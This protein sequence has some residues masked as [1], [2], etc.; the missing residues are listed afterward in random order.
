[1][2]HLLYRSIGYLSLNVLLTFLCFIDESTPTI[3]SFLCL[4]LA[5]VEYIWV[6]TVC[7]FPLL[8]CKQGRSLVQW[9]SFLLLQWH[10]FHDLPFA[11][12]YHT[13]QN[14]R[15]WWVTRGVSQTAHQSWRSFLP[16]TPLSLLPHKMISLLGKD[17][18]FASAKS[19]QAC[20]GSKCASVYV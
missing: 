17:L 15:P 16:Q 2:F 18:P 10:W 4:L 14:H 3:L 11:R 12:L 8:F 9:S 19:F 13:S 6:M 20:A 1:M 7:S 5:G